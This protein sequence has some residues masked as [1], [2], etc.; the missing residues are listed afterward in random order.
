MVEAGKPHHIAQRGALVDLLRRLARL[1]VVEGGDRVERDQTG[2]DDHRGVSAGKLR[3][4][5]DL[6]RKV[7][8]DKGGVD[9]QQ[10]L[11]GDVEDEA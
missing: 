3:R 1:A 7:Q 10:R 5:A 8:N 9:P 2:R 4:G 11:G 6:F